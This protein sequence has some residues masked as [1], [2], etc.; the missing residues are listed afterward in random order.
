MSY[1]ER[2]VNEILNEAK[3][4][5]EGL[6]KKYNLEEKDILEMIANY[7][8]KKYR[9]AQGDIEF[10]EIEIN[11]FGEI[12]IKAIVK[13]YGRFTLHDVDKIIELLYKERFKV[14]YKKD[15]II[16]VHYL[17]IHAFDKYKSIFLSFSP[18]YHRDNYSYLEVRYSL[19]A[20]NTIDNL[21]KELGIQLKPHIFE[22]KEK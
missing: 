14:F 6:K 18:F 8:I 7:I 5:F 17:D 2:K 21:C 12:N 1:I 9:I 4:Y 16:D 3:K 11:Y 20:G 13:K 15:S 10:M 22:M 19:G